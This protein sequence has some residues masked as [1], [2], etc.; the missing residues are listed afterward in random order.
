MSS[1]N[2]YHCIFMGKP[3]NSIGILRSYRINVRCSQDRILDTL[4]KQYE[5]IRGLRVFFENEELE[6]IVPEDTIGGVV[7]TWGT[8]S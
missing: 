7:Q 3:I 4:Y 2:V 8:N 1:E 6:T 5:D